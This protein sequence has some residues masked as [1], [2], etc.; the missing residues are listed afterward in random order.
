MSITIPSPGTLICYDSQDRLLLGMV[1]SGDARKTN[2]INLFGSELSL[3]TER[4]ETLPQK[5]R[6]DLPTSE[7]VRLLT[8][9]QENAQGIAKTID[10]D[11]LWQAVNSDDKMYSCAEL[12]QIYFS[13]NQAEQHL[14]LRLLLAQNKIYFKRDGNHFMARSPESVEQLSLAAKIQADQQALR[15]LTRNFFLEKLQAKQDS[16]NEIPVLI[17]PIVN[18]LIKVASGYDPID[19][20][21]HKDMVKLIS[22]ISELAKINLHGDLRTQAFNLVSKAKLITPYDHLI[23]IKHGIRPEFSAE[24]IA[25]TKKIIETADSVQA[26]AKNIL[27]D[28][29][30]LKAFTIDDSSTRDMDDA[31]SI[32]R[33]ANGDLQLGV[34]IT[35]CAA[36]I[37]SQSALNRLAQARATSIYCPERVVN[38][39]PSELSEDQLSLKPDTTRNC[40]SLLI[41]F[42]ADIRIT[43]F[44][45]CL[46]QI[47]SA[48]KMSYDQVDQLLIEQS[49]LRI[50][51][52]NLIAQARLKQRGQDGA[53]TLPKR[54]LRIKIDAQN[55]VSLL[56]QNEGTP[57]HLLVAEMMILA[58]EYFAKFCA[59]NNIPVV[60]RCQRTP[61]Q[62]EVEKLK[63][64]SDENPAKEYLRR[65]I[66]KPSYQS[67]K[68][69][70]HYGLGL[71]H[72]LQATSPIRRYLDLLIQQQIRAFLLDQPLPYS[73]DTVM[74]IAAELDPILSLSNKASRETERYWLLQYIRQNR[75]Q[76]KIIQ[77]TVIRNDKKYALIE[78]NPLVMTCFCKIPKETQPG[79]QI[80]VQIKTL[81]PEF[82]EIQLD[83]IKVLA[84]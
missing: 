2:A 27:R 11:M 81:R 39:L 65:S 56:E 43:K 7:Y 3:P 84:N 26:Q 51:E 6:S 55:K 80:E 24:E 68:P 42:D 64:V 62:A 34:H 14:A 33:D 22:E 59:Q 29:T 19:P 48:Q 16:S 71:T 47:R 41:S 5:L 61:D 70:L 57:A 35:D 58:N 78:L 79:T 52:L 18:T 13:Q 12:C 1:K 77:A 31:L 10:L 15:D 72:Y 44:E 63:S 4:L 38:M 8:E 28:L 17:V 67:S 60:Y 20:K 45:V 23:Y 66:M 36:L 83:F 9:I 69:E 32:E 54:T 49:D 76:F 73:F 21:T 53:N 25:D 74:K 46:S 30:N 40:I 75:E 82:D 37:S 50:T